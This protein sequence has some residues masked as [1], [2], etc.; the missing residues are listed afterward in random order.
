[1]EYEVFNLEFGVVDAKYSDT[2]IV[3]VDG[4]DGGCDKLHDFNVGYR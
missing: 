4:S 1:M 3:I 2:R